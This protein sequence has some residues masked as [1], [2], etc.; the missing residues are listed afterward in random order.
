MKRCTKH[1]KFP[2]KH[3]QDPSLMPHIHISMILS[4]LMISGAII[5]S[6]RFWIQ[7]CKVN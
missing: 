2:K 5:F 7:T 4:T 6:L 1:K 3:L